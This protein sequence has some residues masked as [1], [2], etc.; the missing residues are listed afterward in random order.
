MDTGDSRSERVRTGLIGLWIVTCLGSLLVGSVVMYV[1]EGT[2][3]TGTTVTPSVT[4]IPS[5][6]S[7]QAIKVEVHV[8]FPT[9]TPQPTEGPTATV[10]VPATDWCSSGVAPGA[11]CLKDYPTPRPPTPYP[12]CDSPSA[13]SGQACIWPTPYPTPGSLFP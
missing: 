10:T 2:I 4:E 13:N 5:P 8:D 12:S 11:V 3:L 9:D 7:S 1:R 6:P